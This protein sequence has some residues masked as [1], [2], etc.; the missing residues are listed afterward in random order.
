MS[1]RGF[2]DENTN[3]STNNNVLVCPIHG[4][5]PASMKAFGCPICR[6]EEIDEE[7]EEEMLDKSKLAR[8]SQ[9][10]KK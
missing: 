6:E 7:N 10:R 9:P 3:N 1:F 5:Y 4:E 8:F 2:F